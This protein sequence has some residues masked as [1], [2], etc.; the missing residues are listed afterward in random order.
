MTTQYQIGISKGT[1]QGEMIKYFDF[2]DYLSPSSAVRVAETIFR[3][4]DARGEKCFAR[5]YR[6]RKEFAHIVGDSTSVITR[7][8]SHNDVPDVLP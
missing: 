4:F 1:G 6:D 2:G 7:Y 8:K 5:V 3:Y